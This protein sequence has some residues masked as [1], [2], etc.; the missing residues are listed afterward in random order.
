[1]N[2]KFIRSQQTHRKRVT[3]YGSP[4][5]HCIGNQGTECGTPAQR[6]PECLVFQP[7]DCGDVFWNTAL[8]S[9]EQTSSLLQHEYEY[10]CSNITMNNISTA[11]LRQPRLLYTHNITTR[12]SGTTTGSGTTNGD[13]G[14]QSAGTLA[15]T[16]IL[17]RGHRNH[18]NQA[19]NP[20][21]TY[22]LA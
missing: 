16:C 20:G 6:K 15:G 22:K 21:T 1:M 2:S 12:I 14:L 7:R 5:D 13:D 11:T 10:K 3:S 17:A 18:T 19:S 9:I 4:R 8:L